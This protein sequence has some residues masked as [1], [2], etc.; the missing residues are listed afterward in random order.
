M[1]TRNH[2][3]VHN[4]SRTS[5]VENLM[6]NSVCICSPGLTA[7][8]L[9]DK[10]RDGKLMTVVDGT[11]LICRQVIGKETGET[12]HGRAF[13]VVFFF[14]FKGFFAIPLAEPGENIPFQALYQIWW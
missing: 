4:V 7:S 11:A 8:S 1:A 10:P 2:M 12:Q 14:F 6:A 5:K 9:L 3:I 13:V